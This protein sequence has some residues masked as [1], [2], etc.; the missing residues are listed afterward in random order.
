MRRSK[1]NYRCS[2]CGRDKSEA[3]ILIAGIDGHICEVCVEQADEIIQ[4]ELYSGRKEEERQDFFLPETVTPQELKKQLD[5]YVIGQDEAKKFLSVAVYNHY[6]RLRQPKDTDIEIEK[7]NILLV[8]RT[9]TGKTLLAKTIAKFLNA[10]LGLLNQALGLPNVRTGLEQHAEPLA[11]LLVFP[12]DVIV[13][14]VR[15]Q[16][17][18]SDGPDRA[19]ATIRRRDLIVRQIRKVGSVFFLEHHP[20]RNLPSVL[21]FEAG[22]C[23]SGDR[24]AHGPGKG[25]RIHTQSV[26]FRSIDV[27]SHLVGSIVITGS[28]LKEV[29]NARNQFECWLQVGCD[30][31]EKLWI[32]SHK[33]D[34]MHIGVS[35]PALFGGIASPLHVNRDPRLLRH[36][37]V[38]QVHRFARGELVFA[39][40]SKKT[41]ETAL[42]SS[43]EELV[44]LEPVGI[45]VGVHVRLNPFHIGQALIHGVLIGETDMN[46]EVTDGFFLGPFGVELFGQQERPGQE[47]NENHTQIQASLEEELQG[48]IVT[49]VETPEGPQIE[50][51]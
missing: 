23:G 2:F 22:Q 19:H 5:Q 34:V 36:I 20:D 35:I 40:R 15:H 46:T 9:G 4:E 43:V 12:L 8:G 39:I 10:G 25:S 48:T 33:S 16:F 24:R 38:E 6:K 13:V 30:L 3:L 14:V 21:P 27:E 44:R 28:I 50:F 18:P 37:V 51:G 1:N 42:P 45:H 26:G 32:V 7:S 11:D 41:G 31:L 47:H 17:H 49:P 29:H